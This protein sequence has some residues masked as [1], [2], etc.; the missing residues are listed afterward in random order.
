MDTADA[1]AE[2][3]S[4]IARYVDD[5]GSGDF[6]AL[7][8]EAFAFQYQGVEPYRRLCDGRGARP[9]EVE[10]WQDVPPVPTAA[11]KSLEITTAAE[12]DAEGV[13][14]FRS[15]GTREGEERRSVH[16]HPY[17]DLY[18][19]TVDRAFPAVCPLTAARPPILAL[20]PDRE[21][22]P[23]SSLSFMVDH[24]V[25]HHGGDGSAHAFGRRGV[26][27][28]TLRSWLGARQ[29]DGRSALVLATTFALE[30]AV[31]TLERFG[32]RFR[33]PAG[34][35]VMDTG[36]YKGRQREVARGELLAAVDEHLGVPP[37]RVFGEYGMTEL[38]SQLYTRNL[39]GGP[40][41][42]YRGPHWVR[43]RTLDPATLEPAAPG[44]PGLI[45]VFDLANLGSAVH[46]LTEDLGRLHADGLELLGRAP[47]A[48]L[49]GC[50]LTVENLGG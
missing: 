24:L 2:L 6:D 8:L 28:R 1:A 31:E 11:F 46:L 43:L 33:L 10:R 37:Q 20:V 22:A 40:A 29:R 18:R 41:E 36:G 34:S 45:A 4:R 26:D 7:A 19:R 44:A 15:S 32:L 16:R 25:H 12:P 23:D 30:D 48:E 17:P 47:G 27:G 3:P 39:V 38:T 50:S 35:A 49:R 21:Q 42:R 9:G 5:P 13:E 14:T